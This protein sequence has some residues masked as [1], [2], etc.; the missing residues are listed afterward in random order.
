MECDF[1]P[2]TVRLYCRIRVC[3][4]EREREELQQRFKFLLKFKKHTL[5]KCERG[6]LPG[7]NLR[8]WSSGSTKRAW[9]R[10]G[11]RLHGCGLIK[12]R[13]QRRRCVCGGRDGRQI[14]EAGSALSC[15][16]LAGSSGSS[17]TFPQH[18]PD[19]DYSISKST[20]RTSGLRCY[21][22]TKTGSHENLS[23]RLILIMYEN[24]PEML[25]LGIL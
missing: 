6:S 2:T 22:G 12:T 9:S 25:I 11:R 24:H 8:N 3:V 5:L 13:W 1:K 19:G 4:C 20:W 17:R 10:R 16:P 21:R 23:C 18:R 15:F 14:V 7:W